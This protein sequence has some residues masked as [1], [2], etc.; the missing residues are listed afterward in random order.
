MPTLRQ[1]GW[2]RGGLGR[3][4]IVGMKRGGEGRGVVVGRGETGRGGR[5]EGMEW[6]R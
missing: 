4:G 5:A 3:R 6:G 1:N 2:G